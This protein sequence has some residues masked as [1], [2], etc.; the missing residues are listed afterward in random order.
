MDNHVARYRGY[1][2]DLCLDD[3]VTYLIYD[4]SSGGYLEAGPLYS[5]YECEKYIDNL[6][7]L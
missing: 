1:S 4:N 2:I 5:I 3:L 7:D 6:E